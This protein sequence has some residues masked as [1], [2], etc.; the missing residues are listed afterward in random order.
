M[1]L[2]GSQLAPPT[3]LGRVGEMHC[4]HSCGSSKVQILQQASV[5]PSMKEISFQRPEN[6]KKVTID[7]YDKEELGN[8]KYM[9]PPPRPPLPLFKDCP[10][11]SG[12]PSDLTGHTCSV[13]QPKGCCAVPPGRLGAPP[14]PAALPDHPP[15][16]ERPFLP[17]LSA[18][19]VS[20]F[21]E[22]GF[23]D[24]SRRTVKFHYIIV[25][26]KLEASGLFPV[27]INMM[28]PAILF[29]EELTQVKFATKMIF[30]GEMCFPVTS[31]A[32]MLSD[33]CFPS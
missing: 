3:V 22:S 4:N 10:E 7:G 13:C 5:V 21:A 6:T 26:F 27:G 31:S 20:Q 15:P 30:P 9:S 2:S 16:R 14:Q 24:R 18:S 28:K 17:T 11:P 19:S 32:I 29:P 8:K 1:C 23:E 12:T 25:D 33:T